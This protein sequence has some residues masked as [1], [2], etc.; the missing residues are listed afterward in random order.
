M[1]QEYIDIQK[2]FFSKRIA[3]YKLRMRRLRRRRR[4]ILWFG[5]PPCLTMSSISAITTMA[6]VNKKSEFQIVENM[7][8]LG[9]LL[10]HISANIPLYFLSLVIIFALMFSL[11]LQIRE[12]EIDVAKHGIEKCK[13]YHK[14]SEQD[15]EDV[16]CEITEDRHYLI[17]NKSSFNVN[18]LELIKSFIT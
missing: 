6:V 10:P 12:D 4:V 2:K 5:L 7:A 14:L 8:T 9:D 16:L 3:N 17:K 15:Q 11:L 18:I 1:N 13:I